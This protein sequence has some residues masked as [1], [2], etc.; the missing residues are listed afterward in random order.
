[1]PESFGG[2]PAPRAQKLH[3]MLGVVYLIICA[4]RHQGLA[5]LDGIAEVGVACNATGFQGRMCLFE[6][7]HMND[8]FHQEL[9]STY[10]KT[11][12]I[13]MLVSRGMTT[14]L[15]DALQKSANGGCDNRR[16]PVPFRPGNRAS[17][18][19]FRGRNWRRSAISGLSV[20]RH[21]VAADRSIVQLPAWGVVGGVSILWHKTR[22]R[23]KTGY[24]RPTSHMI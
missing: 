21:R 4:C 10:E 5:K 24:L 18:L 3:K 14:L 22:I 7:L 20:L 8:R 6:V 12:L 17:I 15:S 11:R 13:N 23:V 1:M 9:T 19:L 16:S 2:E